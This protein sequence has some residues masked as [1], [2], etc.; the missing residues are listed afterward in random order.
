[1]NCVMHTCISLGHSHI[2]DP[3]D[4]SVLSIAANE[5]LPCIIL[6]CTGNILVSLTHNR[7]L[8]KAGTDRSLMLCVFRAHIPLRQ[9]RKMY[10]SVVPLWQHCDR[11]L[12]PLPQIT[13]SGRS[14]AAV[15]S[16]YLLSIQHFFV[17]METTRG[18]HINNTKLS[19][20]ISRGKFISTMGRTQPHHV[21]WFVFIFISHQQTYPPKSLQSQILRISHSCLLSMNL[22]S[23]PAGQSPL[24]SYIC[25]LL[26][27]S[28]PQ[29]V[30]A[31]ATFLLKINI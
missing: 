10:E 25:N 29:S 26:W 22:F 19:T 24:L 30:S 17:S 12:G 31:Q 23:C 27:K 7:H 9:F 5:H 11:Q 6:Y 1:M 2:L 21:Q 15:G 14:F 28:V 8:N 18:Q 4:K 3:P 13:A 16:E 20:V